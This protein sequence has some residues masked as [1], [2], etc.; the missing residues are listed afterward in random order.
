MMTFSLSDIITLLIAAYFIFL[1]KG[2]A[3][4][5][6]LIIALG[7]AKRRPIDISHLSIQPSIKLQSTMDHLVKLG[8]SQ[9]GIIR[10]KISSI[11]NLDA[12]ILIS[13]DRAVQ[14]ELTEITPN[15]AGFTTVYDDHAFLETGFP[16]GEN[17][18]WP[19]YRSHTIASNI[20]D[21]YHHQVQQMDVFNK[22]HGVPHKIETISDYLFWDAEFRQRFARKKMSRLMWYGVLGIVA[23]GYGGIFALGTLGYSLLRGIDLRTGLSFLLMAIAPIAFICVLSTFYELWSDMIKAKYV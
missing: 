18:E 11:Q 6:S 20:E 23:L 15:A 14:A 4:I 2:I 17:I 21:A 8:F 9:V 1:V 12:W 5:N 3:G 10:V 13:L 19:D 7:V 16:Y 22:K